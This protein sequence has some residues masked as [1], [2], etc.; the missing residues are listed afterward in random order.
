MVLISLLEQSDPNDFAFLI[1]NNELFIPV[2]PRIDLALSYNGGESFGSYISN[3]LNPIGVYKNMLR[4]W[5]L[6]LANDVVMQ[7]RV[8]GYGAICCGQM[9]L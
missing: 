2:T 9:D 3:I 4:W 8:L 5:Q 6:G 1:A 7:F